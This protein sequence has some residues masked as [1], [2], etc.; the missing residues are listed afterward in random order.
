MVESSRFDIFC[1]N[2]D[3]DMIETFRTLIPESSRT[4]KDVFQYS[5]IIIDKANRIYSYPLLGVSLSF[6]S[7]PGR[8][9]GN[10]SHS[11][12]ENCCINL[13]DYDFSSVGTGAFTAAPTPETITLNLKDLDLS[14]SDS[15]IVELRTDNALI[16]RKLNKSREF[17]LSFSQST[18]D[19]LLTN[20]SLTIGLGDLAASIN[21]LKFTW[22]SKNKANQIDS[23]KRT[24]IFPFSRK[25]CNRMIFL[26]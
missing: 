22:Y 15:L 16:N 23:E 21:E 18:F 5:L 4:T 24:L 6:L 13:E 19:D 20:P 26:R 25:I 14:F 7:P 17:D 12:P 8:F 3:K 10:V 9:F 11:I 1:R 2:I